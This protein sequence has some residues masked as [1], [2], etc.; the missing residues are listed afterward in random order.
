MKENELGSLGQVALSCIYGCCTI[1]AL[2]STSI[3]KWL[4]NY[5]RTFTAAGIFYTLFVACF[6]LPAFMA[7][8]VANDPEH[9]IPSSGLLAK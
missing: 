4:G 7:K 5:S 1:S 9:I 6:L 2:F 8:K 3:R